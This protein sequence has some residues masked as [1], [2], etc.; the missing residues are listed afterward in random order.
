MALT[1]TFLREQ[2]QLQRGRAADATLDN[3]RMIA[4]KAADAWGREAALAER[5]ESRSDR[6]E[7]L[8]EAASSSEEEDDRDASA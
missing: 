8:P 2:E 4:T 3:V 6:A 5:R 1:S 7:A